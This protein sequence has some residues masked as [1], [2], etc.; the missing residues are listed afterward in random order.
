MRK[1]A[2]NGYSV[3]TLK[4]AV[5]E[6]KKSH[7]RKTVFIILGVIIAVIFALALGVGYLLKKRL[8]EDEKD[9]D[10]DFEDEFF[11]EHNDDI[12]H[13]EENPAEVQ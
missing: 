1:Y 2:D 11:E 5:E 13:I 3:A 9:W 8:V 4:E 6:I 7:D 12:E 10:D